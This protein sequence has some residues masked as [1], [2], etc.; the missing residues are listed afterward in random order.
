MLF[1]SYL[2][3]LGLFIGSFLNVVIDRLANDQSLLGRSHCD[4]CQHKL[5][6][7]DLIPVLS[8]FLLGRKCRYC[9]KKLMWQY[10][11]VELATGV[12]F[13]LTAKTFF[14][15]TQS[16]ASLQLLLYLGIISCLIIIFVVDIKYQIIP[17]EIQI[18]FFVFVLGLKIITVVETQSIASLP[19]N[20]IYGFLVMLPILLLHLLT[21][22][23]GMGFGD[24]KFAYV[25]GF[26][27]GL[28][29]GLLSLYLG[30]ILGAIIGLFL[31][32]LGKKKIKSKIAFGP[33]LVLGVTIMLFWGQ[34]VL[35]LV[36][37]IYGI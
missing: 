37:R 25:I 31:I 6:V 35:D 30:F 3:L 19:I 17:D 2:F 5:G 34:P 27:L 33:F 22:G 4:H 9:K 14:V 26:L 29:S 20:F 24:V 36:R 32:F 1:Y 18:A 21:R 28:K 16:I 15:E 10:P 8:F 12:M 23:R 11:I 7:L 13:F